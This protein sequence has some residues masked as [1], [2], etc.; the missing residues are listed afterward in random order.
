[1]PNVI[2]ILPPEILPPS[3]LPSLSCWITSKTVTNQNSHDQNGHKSDQNGHSKN[4][5]R[6]HQ[7]WGGNVGLLSLWVSEQVGPNAIRPFRGRLLS[8]AQ[9][10]VTS[11]KRACGAGLTKSFFVCAWGCVAL[12]CELHCLG[13]HWCNIQWPWLIPT[14]TAPVLSCRSESC[15]NNVAVCQLEMSS[16]SH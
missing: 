8:T 5:K 11:T 6:P 13:N 4:P 7:K 12:R 2:A 10:R 3:N 16:W 9:M 14:A 15:R 1:M